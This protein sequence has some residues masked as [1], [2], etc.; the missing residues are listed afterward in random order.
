[1]S[2]KLRRAASL[3][4]KAL[5]TEIFRKCPQLA[6]GLATPDARLV[7]LGAW[8]GRESPRSHSDVS[9]RACARGERCWPFCVPCLPAWF[10]ATG[11]MH[12]NSNHVEA[13]PKKDPAN[14]GLAP[15]AKSGEAS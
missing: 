10:G 9:F 4:D 6:N 15:A 5:T 8:A 1:M 3:Q 7:A 11:D 2:S 13:D 12:A 14:L